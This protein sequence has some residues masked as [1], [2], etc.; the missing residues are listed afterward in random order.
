MEGV[1]F[2]GCPLHPFRDKIMN[3]RSELDKNIIKTIDTARRLGHSQGLID[4][5]CAVYEMLIEQ[6]VDVEEQGGLGSRVRS[7]AAE[8]GVDVAEPEIGIAA[9]A[10]P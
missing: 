10:A 1:T 7:L 6:G 3:A 8:R 2:L 5:F 4:A 9:A